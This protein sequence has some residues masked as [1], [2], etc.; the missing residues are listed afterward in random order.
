MSAKDDWPRE[1]NWKHVYTRSEKMKR[2]KQLGMEYPV[3]SEHKRIDDEQVNVLFVC[4]RNQWRS[5]TAERMFKGHPVIVARSA[6]TSLS[7]RHRISHADIDWADVIMVME[8]KHRQRIVAEYARLVEH[9][10]I[11]VLDIPDEYR[12][13]DPELID[14]LEQTVEPL[15][16][17]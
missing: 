11:H 6:G 4:S 7:A 9:T 13:M 3:V 17:A 15:L 5:P 14:I 10:P 8:D 1:K 16:F 12:Y 2:A